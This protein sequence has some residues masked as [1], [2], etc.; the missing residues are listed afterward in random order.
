MIF[1]PTPL[2]GSHLVD[3]EPFQD[4]RGWFARV[5]CA[6]EFRAVAPPLAWV[7]INHSFTRRALTLRGLHFQRPPHQETKL[8]RCVAGAVWDVIVDL[9]RG[10][11]TFL[12][13]FGAELSAAN[14]TMLLV[15]PGFAHGFQTLAADTEIIYHHSHPDTP[16]AEGGLRYDDPRLGIAWPAAPA[17]LSARDAAHPRLDGGFQGF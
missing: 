5:F 8:V 9:R 16:D 4:E 14:R 3:P 12:K 2:G 10:S 1:R 6:E 17:C 15:P 7:Q 11:P 13:W